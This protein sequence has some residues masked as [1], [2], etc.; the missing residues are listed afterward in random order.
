MLNG[1]ESFWHHDVMHLHLHPIMIM[2]MVYSQ[3]LLYNSP[4]TILEGLPIDLL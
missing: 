1:Q 3:F 2:M 4:L